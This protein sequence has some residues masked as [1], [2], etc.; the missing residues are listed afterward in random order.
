MGEGRGGGVGVWGKNL[1][2]LAVWGWVKLGE[3]TR[4]WGGGYWGGLRGEHG[5]F[6]RGRLRAGGNVG[7][8]LRDCKK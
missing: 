3:D 6:R 5:E 7:L 2:K 1:R 4:K 8:G